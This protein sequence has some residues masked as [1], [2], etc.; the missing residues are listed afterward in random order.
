MHARR[1]LRAHAPTAAC[2]LLRAG[3]SPHHNSHRLLVRAWPLQILRRHEFFTQYG[4]IVKLVVNRNHLYDVNPPL[5]PCLSVYVTYSRKEDALKCIDAVDGCIL[6]R[7]VLRGSFGTTAPPQIVR[8]E[9]SDPTERDLVYSEGDEIE[10]EFDMATSRARDEGGR[11][12]LDNFFALSSFEEGYRNPA[13]P[14]R[15]GDAYS[16]YWSSS[17]SSV[18]A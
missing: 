12:Y 7:R 6:D 4:K 16:A 9:A 13:M 14:T 11:A 3:L 10:I 2:A 1:R 18:A 5:G 17:L 8:F 15:L